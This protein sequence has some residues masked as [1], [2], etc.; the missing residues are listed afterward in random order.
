MNWF[1]ICFFA[2]WLI[3]TIAFAVLGFIAIDTNQLM[4]EGK[5]LLIYGLAV[6]EFLITALL[7]IALEE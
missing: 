6:G 5:F 7:G 2:A 4:I 3:V 1:K